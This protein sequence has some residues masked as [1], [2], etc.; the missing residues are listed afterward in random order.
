MKITAKPDLIKD[1]LEMVKME[2]DDFELKYPYYMSCMDIEDYNATSL[3]N[4]FKKFN[5]P[6]TD[7]DDD[8]ECSDEIV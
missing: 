6:Y 2:Q 3:G 5:I 8:L 4:V 1:L 7:S